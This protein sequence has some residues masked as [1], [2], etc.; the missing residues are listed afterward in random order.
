MGPLVSVLMTAYNRERYISEA[1]DSVL[2]ST[3][4]H[5][6]LIIVDDGSRDDTVSIATNYAA[7]DKR[8]TVYV[9]ERNLG[10]YPNR[11]RAA[12]YA[13]GE[14][15]MYCDSDDTFLPTALQ[16]CVSTMM[17]HP[18]APFGMYW[19]HSDAAPFVLTPEMAIHKHFFERPFLTIGP[20][21]T[22]IRN[23][24]FKAVKG[25][26]EKYGPANDAYYNLKCSSR[27]PILMLPFEFVQYRRHEGQ[28]INN[29]YSYLYNLYLYLRDALEDLDL[30]LLPK[31]RRWVD[32]KNKRRFFVNLV[33]FFLKTGDF[34]RLNDLIR[35][36]NF[37]YKD[38]YDAIF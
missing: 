30:H 11:N 6:E 20:G 33:R 2:A 5:F 36:T 10:D 22:I 32:K 29:T 37:G 31:E 26:P 17:L 23:D 3:Y 13:G 19:L 25:F 16:D 21:G 7:K 38:V 12:S 34:K 18:E 24:F 28:E 4:P 15:L 8:I 1:I 9:N 27:A 14:F 35:R